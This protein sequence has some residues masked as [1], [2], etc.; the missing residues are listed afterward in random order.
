MGRMAVDSMAVVVLVALAAE[1]ATQAPPYREEE[2]TFHSAD[3]T[4]AGTL[5][6]PAGDGPFPAVV[7]LSGSGPQ[8]RDSSVFGFPLFRPIAERLAQAGIAVLRCDDRGVGGSSGSVT[9]ATTATFAD[10]ALAAIDFLR[11]RPD[12][13]R[14]SVGLFGHSE[15]AV[16]AALAAS[17]SPAVAFIVWMAGTARPGAEVLAGQAATLARLT[18]ASEEEVATIAAAHRRLLEAVRRGAPDDEVKEA[19]RTLARAQFDALPEAQRKMIGDVDAVLT[20]MVDRHAQALRSPWMRFF[21]DFDPAQALARVA[22]PVLA[23]FGGRDLQVP[24]AAHRAPLEAALARGGNSRLTVRVYPEAN[25]LFQKAG[26]GSPAEY[27][28][29]DKAFVPSLLDDVAAWV[30]AQSR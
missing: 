23:V 21:I 11:A 3:A 30:A 10:D 29:L 2:I 6:I 1:G 19:V 28:T 12:I 5:T 13:R 26:T 17:R 15:G 8:D 16:T 9:D 14:T 7:L 27:A 20:G 4:I 25:H 22:C 24:P 18:G